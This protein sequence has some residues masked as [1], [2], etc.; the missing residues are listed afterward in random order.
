M[1]RST[2]FSTDSMAGMTKRSLKG[3]ALALILSINSLQSVT[4]NTIEEE[5][6]GTNP[7]H[8]HPVEHGIA[9][10]FIGAVSGAAWGLAAGYALDGGNINGNNTSLW[11]GVYGG[12]I[13][14]A[15]I[16]VTI[17]EYS[18]NEQF[19]FGRQLWNYG[20]YGFII[21]GTVGAAGGAIAGGGDIDTLM[22]GAGWGVIAGIP[23]LII[24]SF[25]FED[26][27]SSEDNKGSDTTAAQFGFGFAPDNQ[28]RWTVQ[29]SSTI[30]F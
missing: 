8:F 7:E 15:S 30:R 6:L 29:T 27:F 12:A 26:Y 19:I 21:G 11:A 4:A 2:F 24:G 18:D 5:Y 1:T 13:G 14:V 3:F 23:A 16:F 25:F 20:W 9:N 22:K 17:K 10:F 28:G